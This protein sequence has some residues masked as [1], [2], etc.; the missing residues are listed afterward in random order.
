MIH[1]RPRLVSV[2]I[3][4]FSNINPT[5]SCWEA[6]SWEH[7]N[8]FV[9]KMDINL[10]STPQRTASSSL[11]HQFAK[12][13]WTIQH[14]PSTRA[15]PGRLQSMAAPIQGALQLHPRFPLDP[16]LVVRQSM[17]SQAIL[18]VFVVL[19]R[20]EAAVGADMGVLGV[21]GLAGRECREVQV[22]VRWAMRVH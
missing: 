22:A 5:Y 4:I 1:K 11:R 2:R 9:F 17:F 10:C 16:A 8:I 15:L 3:P 20:W 6:T 13:S 7:L 19:A 21:V 12:H 18:V 14:H